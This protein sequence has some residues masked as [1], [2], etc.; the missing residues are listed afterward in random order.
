MAFGRK[1]HHRVGLVLLEQLAQRRAIA[2]ALLLERV[3]RI[4]RGAGQRIE[5]GG[6]GQLVDIDDARM[7]VSQQMPDHR[8]ADEAGAAG[9][10]DRG[11]SETHGI[12]LASDH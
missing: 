12:C 8:R 6:I 9:D 7:G 2:D 1:I 4:G 11:S 5:I 3:M 10:E